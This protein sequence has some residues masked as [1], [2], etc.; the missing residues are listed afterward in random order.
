MIYVVMKETGEILFEIDAW[1][2]NAEEKVSAWMA[3]NGYTLVNEEITLMGNK[4]VWVK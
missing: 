3:E 1:Y 4:V 2:V